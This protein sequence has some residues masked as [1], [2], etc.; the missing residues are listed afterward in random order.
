MTLKGKLL[1]LVVTPVLVCTTIAVLVSSFKIRN[2][3]IEGLEDKSEAILKQSIEEFTI[4]HQDGSSINEDNDDSLVENLKDRG[5]RNYEFRI[6]SPKPEN[7]KHK[8]N[9]KENI[10]IKQ[11]EEE[12]SD[13]INYIDKESHILWVMK[14]VFMSKTKGCLECHGTRKSDPVQISENALRGIFIVKSK[15]DNTE[16]QVSS[17]IYQISIVGI[18]IIVVSIIF[19]IFFIVKISTAIQQII[20]VSRKISDGDLRDKVSINTGDELEELGSYINKMIGSLNHVLEGVSKLSNKLTFSTKEIANTSNALS[21]GASESAATLEEVSSTMEEMTANIETSNEKAEHTEKISLV[22]Y[23]E[24]QDVAGS[25]GKVVEANK[26]IA[27]KINIINDI[28][29]QTNILALNAAVE[30]ARA[31]EGGK[32]FAVVATE[33]RRLAERSKISADE[34]VNLSLNSYEI[35][36]NVGKKMNN[37]IPEN[38]KISKMIQEIT[39]SNSEH[40]NG[41]TQINNAIQQLN[42]VTQQNASASEELATAADELANQADEL[43]ELISFFKIHD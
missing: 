15:M 29:F 41:A 3:G 23:N 12:K 36:V 10:F 31:G 39:A 28:A 5:T 8:S 24:M 17:A 37:L 22:T 40:T 35:A 20:L 42:S 9:D 7:I 6:S 43:N 1:I 26:T 13:Q 30:A 33:V 38:E 27:D 16:A 11:F 2:Q 4:H 32:G 18:I 14:P 21:Q 34:I 25:A 19:G